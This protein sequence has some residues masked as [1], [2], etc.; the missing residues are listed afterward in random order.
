MSMVEKNKARLC[1]HTKRKKPKDLTPNAYRMQRPFLYLVGRT[2]L[3]CWHLVVACSMM[4][5]LSITPEEFHRSVQRAYNYC[6]GFFFSFKLLSFVL[7]LTYYVYYSFFKL[8]LW[9]SR[10]DCLIYLNKVAKSCLIPKGVCPR[11]KSSGFL[12]LLFLLE[13]LQ[14]C[15]RIF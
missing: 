5:Y 1:H 8:C 2:I 12:L 13:D 6:V 15:R 9:S 14:K 3:Q 4:S 11:G 10:V 7:L